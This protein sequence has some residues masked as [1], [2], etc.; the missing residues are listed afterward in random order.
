MFLCLRFLNV[1]DLGVLVFWR[2]MKTIFFYDRFFFS[3][4]ALNSSII[5]ISGYH[6]TGVVLSPYIAFLSQLKCTKI[7]CT[8]LSTNQAASYEETDILLSFA[9]PAGALSGA[10]VA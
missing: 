8:F 6:F 9:F 3:F 4:I 1:F 10:G 5:F 7:N 2:T